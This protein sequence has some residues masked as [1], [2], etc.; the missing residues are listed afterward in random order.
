[1]GEE[2]YVFNFSNAQKR[3]INPQG[4]EGKIHAKP[5][6]SHLVSRAVFSL[7]F[8]PSSLLSLLYLFFLPSKLLIKEGFEL[9]SLSSSIFYLDSFGNFIQ[10]YI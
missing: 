1:M 8:P 10:F 2:V 5:K 6:S 9:N 7:G 4:L 3:E